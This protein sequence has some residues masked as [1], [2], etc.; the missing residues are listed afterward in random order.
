MKFVSA[1]LPACCFSSTGIMAKPPIYLPKL[2]IDAYSKARYTIPTHEDTIK[3]LFPPSLSCSIHVAL[4]CPIMY[5][6]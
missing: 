2:G 1:G 6:R 3:F 4:K 5:N